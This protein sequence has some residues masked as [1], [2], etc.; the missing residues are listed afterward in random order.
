MFLEVTD[1]KAGSSE[2]SCFVSHRLSVVNQKFE[3]DRCVPLLPCCIC[4]DRLV[5]LLPCYICR[6]KE[7]CAADPEAL[8]DGSCS[9][10]CP[11]SICCCLRTLNFRLQLSHCIAA[12]SLP[13][14]L[15]SNFES[16]RQRLKAV[17]DY[18]QGCFEGVPEPLQQVCKGLGLA[19]VSATAH[20]V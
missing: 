1:S 4:R 10:G 17:V 14:H 18:L 2:W 8:L 7:S 12:G 15:N 19:G 16:S 3:G 9:E 6:L 20:P 5:H 13:I 11:T